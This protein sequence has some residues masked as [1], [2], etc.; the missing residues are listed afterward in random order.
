MDPR[1]LLAAARGEESS[2]LLLENARLV[3]VFTAEIYETAI[4]IRGSRI[5]GLGK[6]YRAENVLDLEGRF[7]APGLIDAHVHIESSMVPPREFARM[8]L[9]RGV[10]TVVA[11]PHEIANVRGLEGIRFMLESARKSSLS[12]FF[13]APSCV[14]ASHLETSGARLLASDLAQLL[15]EPEVIGLAEVMNFPG[16]IQGDDEVLAKLRA[17]EGRVIDGHCPRLTGLFLNA[18]AASGIGSDHE[19]TEIAEAREKLRLGMM[20]FLREGTAARNLKNLAPLVTRE[21][22]RR[23]CLCTDDRHCQDLLDEGSI[24]YLIRTA[25]GEGIDP[26][27]TI[28]MASLNAA[29]YFRLHD[30]GAIAPGRRADLVVFSDLNSPEIELVFKDGA[31]VAR[32]GVLLENGEPDRDA[33]WNG[34]LNV[35]WSDLS[36]SV[37][38]E[39][40]RIR[41]IGCTP[42]ELVT[43]GLTMD[44]SIESGNAIADTR[45]DL[46]KMMVIE[47]HHGT[48]NV[49]MG[50]VRGIGL[51]RGAIAG[52]VA[53]DHHNLVII[54]ADD[55]SMK[56]AAEA[57]AAAGGGQAAAEKDR[58]LA[59]V[60]LPIGGLMSGRPACE[61]GED[62]RS[63]KRAARALGSPAPDPFTT[64]SFLALEVVPSLKL[65]DLGLVDVE[66]FELV[67]L[68][69]RD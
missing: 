63:L 46:L 9:P 43:E 50:F 10:T 8:V 39:G 1:R 54:G 69:V 22:E 44:A 60:A 4:A 19:C 53:H 38:A 65:T 36:F 58:V 32:D 67:P 27:T 37:P 66:K 62:V 51:T 68:F 26:L 59:R 28:R 31:L 3:N 14:P 55:E 12:F 18:Y 30:R 34:P 29:E 15:K 20:V 61:V 6:G 42:G 41:V 25:I 21:N 56:T 45:R 13:T 11:D 2:D 33:G 52:T 16:V 24:D 48:G 57:V 47:R 7:V 35:R 40:R 23:L 17:F 49:G 64:M 5:A